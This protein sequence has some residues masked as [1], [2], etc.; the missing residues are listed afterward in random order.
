MWFLARDFLLW[1]IMAM[2][3]GIVIGWLWWGRTGADGDRDADRVID[4]RHTDEEL[5]VL[6]AERDR[7]VMRSR[8][9]SEE[10][11]G[12]RAAH[13]E[14][15]RVLEMRAERLADQE[16]ELRAL[17]SRVDE[18]EQTLATYTSLAEEDEDHDLRSRLEQAVLELVALRNSAADNEAALEAQLEQARREL[19]ARD[20]SLRRL[21]EESDRVDEFELIDGLGRRAA[22][23]LRGHG[24]R[25]YAQLARAEPDELRRAL[26]AAGVGFSPSLP[27]WPEQAGRL[28]R[29][30]VEHWEPLVQWQ[31]GSIT[32]G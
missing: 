6:L 32:R 19:A 12:L 17:R 18:V 11:D 24:I 8:E 1:L 7:L 14:T 9:Q 23:A 31:P 15:L 26:E 3:L 29:G 25:T 20:L 13:A 16:G 4:L 28:E 21:S 27:S 10:L 5:G 2:A 30:E 22:I